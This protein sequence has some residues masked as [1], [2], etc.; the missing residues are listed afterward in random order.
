MVWGRAATDIFCNH[1]T[2]GKNEIHYRR[3]NNMIH[4][5][6]FAAIGGSSVVISVTGSLSECLKCTIL[7][8]HADFTAVAK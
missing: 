4:I 2:F 3:H 7:E 6:V 5:A 1:G 8:E